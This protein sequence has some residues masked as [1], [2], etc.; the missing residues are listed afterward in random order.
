M[1]KKETRK[2]NYTASLL[3]FIGSFAFIYVIWSIWMSPP[4][5]LADGISAS[6]PAFGLGLFAASAVLTS[7]ALFIATLANSVYMADG[8]AQ[9]MQMWSWKM[10]M[11]S[12]FALFVLTLPGPKSWLVFIGFILYSVGN[13]M[14]NA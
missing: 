14:S 6:L 3:K 2:P 9:H 12:A 13:M 10:G 5:W 7:F 1:P 11:W 8:T 4:A